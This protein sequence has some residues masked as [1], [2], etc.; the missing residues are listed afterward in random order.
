VLAPGFLV[1]L[2]VLAPL[3][4]LH[5]R[6]RRRRAEVS[7][8]LLWRDIAP[9]GPSRRRRPR[10]VLPLLLVLQAL[11]VGLVAVA[12]TRPGERRDHA[13]QAAAPVAIVVDRSSADA[14][15]AAR[16]RLTRI[17]AGT[18]VT[19]V[20]AGTR[21]RIVARRSVDGLRPDP[22]GDP[23]LASALVLAAGSIGG[24]HGTVVL[25]RGAATPAPRVTAGGGLRFVAEVVG[26]SVAP[27][28]PTAR[29]ASAGRCAA[30]T[31]VRNAG[32]HAVTARVVVHGGD[33]GVVARSVR[34][35]AGASADVQVAARPGARVAFAVDG[36]EEVSVR[37]PSTPATRV[38]LAGDDAGAVARA[39]AAVPG[40][41][42]VGDDGATD[43]MVSVGRAPAASVHAHAL[44][45]V[46]P[47]TL[48][49]G[50]VGD[51]VR[52]PAL[53]GADTS[54]PL[55]TGVDLSTVSVGAGVLKAYTLPASLRAI[56]WTAG[57][58]PLLA[59]GS[60]GGTPTTLLTVDPARSD[61]VRQPAW[62]A[63]IADVVAWSR[64]AASTPPS[65][66]P[67]AVDLRPSGAL[68]HARGRREWWPWLVAGALAMVLVEA[69]LAHRLRGRPA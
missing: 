9:A 68:P 14:R 6:R 36:G 2:A 27:G 5:L 10:V 17:P 33:R 40:V 66:P 29:C 25:I 43:L 34:L 41:R 3:V 13:A 39:L 37:V 47:R 31:T 15:A 21:P 24:S 53:S 20:T 11:V 64:G 55:L 62:P 22:D 67:E 7:A 18:P 54:D 23:D 1:V 56:A 35:A 32:E 49:G 28:R 50:R 59:T 30:L 8:V 12:L 48:P 42:L 44:L 4:A 16:R 69:A 63:L 58:H 51:A 45:L 46:A 52:V 61:L 38:A 60:L 57:D 26:P 19:V 65:A